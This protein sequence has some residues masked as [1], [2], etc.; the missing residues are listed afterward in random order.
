MT[1]H[2]RNRLSQKNNNA[3]GCGSDEI[4]NSWIELIQSKLQ[5]NHL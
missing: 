3:R 1:F 2:C 5:V 4:E